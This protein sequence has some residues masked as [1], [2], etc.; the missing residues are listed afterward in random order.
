MSWTEVSATVLPLVGVA[1]GTAGTLFGQRFATRAD[2]QRD[3]FQRAAAQRTERKEA[4]PI[5]ADGQGEL[6]ILERSLEAD[7]SMSAMREIKAS[8]ELV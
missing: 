8:G 3:E 1:L 6:V 4:I 2:L 5:E 7:P